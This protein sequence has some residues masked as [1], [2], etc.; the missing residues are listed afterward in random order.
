[1]SLNEYGES[2][3]QGIFLTETGKAGR[4]GFNTTNK[5]KIAACAKFKT[6]VESKKMKVNSRSLIGEMK[7]FIAHGGSYA[8][9]I[10]DT[11]DLVMASL[12]AVRMMQQL[13]D[14]HYDLEEQIRDH[15]EIVQPL[16][17]YAVLA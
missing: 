9:K 12:L 2:N 11:D 16:P 6:L 13:G 7:S 10:G 17:F 14:Y 3:I 5:S 4:R 15:D 1:M 8:A